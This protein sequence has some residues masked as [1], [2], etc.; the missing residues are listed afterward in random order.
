LATLVHQAVALAIVA[1]TSA[2]TASVPPQPPVK[3]YLMFVGL[4][5][6]ASKT[7]PVESLTT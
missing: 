5:R 2:F 4:L 1:T 6:V 3:Q 7:A